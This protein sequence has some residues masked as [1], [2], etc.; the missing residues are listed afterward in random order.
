VRWVVLSLVRRVT[1][2][3]K[4]TADAMDACTSQPRTHPATG[5]GHYS[6]YGGKHSIGTLCVLPHPCGCDSA[7]CQ[8]ILPS[9]FIYLP[10]YAHSYEVT[11]SP[12]DLR[13]ALAAAEALSW[14]F[15]PNSGCLR[16]FEGW[17]P[18]PAKHW[19]A[20][21]VIIGEVQIVIIG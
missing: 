2:Q 18:R 5:G 20:Q 10:S 7:V 1:G 13:Q 17:M 19:S 12:E 9:G 21:I 3:F 4:A 8:C 14:A 11:K 15:N 6:S 16:T